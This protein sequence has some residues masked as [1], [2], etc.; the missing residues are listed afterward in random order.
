MEKTTRK[1]LPTTTDKNAAKAWVADGKPT[2][3]RSGWAWKGARQKPITK[4]DA[5]MRLPFY[6][7]GKGFYMLKWDYYN[8]EPCLC[9]NELSACDME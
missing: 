7:F 8:D 2:T 4:H 3:Y 5:F 1:P 9:F 6:D